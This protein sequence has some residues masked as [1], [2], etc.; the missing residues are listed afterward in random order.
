M[1]FDQ[2]VEFTS[3]LGL[4]AWIVAV[5][6]SFW[7][8]RYFNSRGWTF[9]MA[10]SAFIVVR[11]LWKQTPLYAGGKESEVLFNGYMTRFVFGGI[12]AT[13]LSIGLLLLIANYYTVQSRLETQVR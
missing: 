10:G 3:L 6:A 7:V 8:Q 12:G 4:F 5:I 1:S 13:L 2:I 11:Q 9:M